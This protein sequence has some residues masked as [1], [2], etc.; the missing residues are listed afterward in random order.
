MRADED[1]VFSSPLTNCWVCGGIHGSYFSKYIDS[2][3]NEPTLGSVVPLPTQSRVVIIILTIPL[4]AA[5]RIAPA[6][7]ILA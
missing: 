1:P 4:T 7:S 5:Q 2:R 3:W 6:A